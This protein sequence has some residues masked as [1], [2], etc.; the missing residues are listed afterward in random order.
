MKDFLLEEWRI[1][2]M[3]L[4][5]VIVAYASVAILGKNNEAKTGIKVD[6]TP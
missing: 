4:L 6:L 1:I 3:M 2:I 5:M